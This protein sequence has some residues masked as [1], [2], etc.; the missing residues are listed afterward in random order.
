MRWRAAAPRVG[1]IVKIK[2]CA[3]TRQ[4]TIQADAQQRH[5]QADYQS[6]QYRYLPNV[7]ENVVTYLMA[8]DC[9]DFRQGRLVQEIIVECDASRRE[10]TPNI[11][12]DTS[13]LLGRV[14]PFDMIG[15]DQIGSRNDSTVSLYCPAGS[16]LYRLTKAGGT[17]ARSSARS[18]GKR[19]STPSPIS[20]NASRRDA[21]PRK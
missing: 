13:G 7:V 1:A 4:R 15:G 9:L 6:L 16:G 17:R 14:E 3:P 8:E 18:A 12:A 5:R 21:P 10:Q 20:T 11:G 19:S 2:A